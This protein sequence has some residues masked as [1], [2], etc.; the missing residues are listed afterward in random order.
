MFEHGH[1]IPSSRSVSRVGV[2]PRATQGA[3]RSLEGPATAGICDRFKAGATKMAP[4]LRQ[5]IRTSKE[6]VGF[7]LLD[8]PLMITLSHEAVGTGFPR[9][10]FARGLVDERSVHDRG[11]FRRALAVPR[12]VRLHA[13]V[14]ELRFRP[15]RIAF[16]N[17]GGRT[18]RRS[19]RPAPRTR[20]R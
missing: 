10:S 8:C 12:S 1:T 11:E 4:C 17:G 16:R 7:C 5:K 2:P 18:N 15:E 19:F 6:G 14:P 9:S 3:L 13:G 20:F